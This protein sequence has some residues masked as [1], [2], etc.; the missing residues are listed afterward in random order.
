MSG[1]VRKTVASKVKYFYDAPGPNP[2]VARLA[3]AVKGIDTAPLTKRLKLVDGVPGNR[4]S[5]FL[6]KNPA[7]TTPLVE[8]ECGTHIA[9]SL[10]IVQYLDACYDEHPHKLLLSDDPIE[11]AHKLMWYQRVNLQI[12]MPYQRQFQNGEGAAYFRQF[13]PW[14][15]ESV[16]SVPGLRK[17]VVESLKWLEGIMAE[18]DAS[19]VFIGGFERFT[20]ADLQLYTTMNFMLKPSVNRGKVTEKFFPD[21]TF[22]PR[23]KSWYARMEDE[24]AQLEGAQ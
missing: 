23:L 7:G 9:E 24:V 17:Q 8:L 2:W 19:S 15:D 1:A 20:A 5:D 18:D 6:K 16:P 11:A 14:I 13:V 21:E 12:V 22:G 4:T 3:F 10:A